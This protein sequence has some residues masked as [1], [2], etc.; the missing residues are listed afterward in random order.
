MRHRLA[1]WG[2]LCVA[3]A[4]PAA[5]HDPPVEAVKGA[6][7]EVPSTEVVQSVQ[8]GTHSHTEAQPSDDR[9]LRARL[10]DERQ[11]RVQPEAR[12]EPQS[13]G[14]RLRGQAIQQTHA[15]PPPL[16]QVVSPPSRTSPS[17]PPPPPPS[18]PSPPPPPR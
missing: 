16:A 13:D 3:V 2:V 7:K 5:V 11:Q 6:P 1:Y 8:R 17:P 15:E 4:A 18:P 9:Q 14:G 12:T 10:G